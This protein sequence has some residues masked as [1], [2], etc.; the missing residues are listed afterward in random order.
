MIRT[1]EDEIYNRVKN[2]VGFDKSKRFIKW[3]H[4]N[5]PNKE[6]HH[7]AGSFTGIKTSDYFSM[8]VMRE[9][10]LH[11]EKNKSQFCVD[12]LHIYLRIFFEY[13]KDCEKELAKRGK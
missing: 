3:Q 1:K 6:V 11:A 7:L 2:N 12:N 13:V 10:H 9:E 4:E 5:Y 8:P